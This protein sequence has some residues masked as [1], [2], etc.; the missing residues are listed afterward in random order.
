MSDLTFFVDARATGAGKEREGVITVDGHSI[1]F[2][3]PAAMGGKGAGA[4]PETLLISA[5]TA[6][7]SLT[8]LAYL[9]RRHL[10]CSGIAVRTEGVVSGFPQHDRYARISVSPVFNG[11]EA[12]RG[13]EYRAAAVEAC[14]HCFIGQTVATGGVNY[15]VGSVSFA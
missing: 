13:D 14:D 10:P 15:R 12:S 6:C 1:R 9:Q 2:S 4:S 5:V 7:Y 11:G 3:V 8:L